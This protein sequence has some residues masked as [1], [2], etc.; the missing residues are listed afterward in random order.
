MK[1]QQ[2]KSLVLDYLGK[3]GHGSSLND[4][5]G[6]FRKKTLPA[7]IEAA[8]YWEHATIHPHQRRVGKKKID[9]ASLVLQAVGV[10]SRTARA[11]RT[12]A[13]ISSGKACQW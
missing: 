11:R 7:A 6:W 10:L 5:L 2:L 4:Y 12:L 8:G 1:D 3:S 9:Q 13:R